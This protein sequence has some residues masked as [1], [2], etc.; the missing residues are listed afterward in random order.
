MANVHVEPRLTWVIW[1]TFYSIFLILQGIA[2]KKRERMIL[3]KNTQVGNTCLMQFSWFCLLQTGVH[4]HCTK[5]SYCFEIMKRK[6]YSKVFTCKK[7]K[8]K[9]PMQCRVPEF[10]MF[11]SIVY[12]FPFVTLYIVAAIYSFCNTCFIQYLVFHRIA[13]GQMHGI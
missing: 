3:D 8:K 13:I 7:K 4:V 9:L 12:I 1:V 10:K 6:S 2:K 5:C 11:H